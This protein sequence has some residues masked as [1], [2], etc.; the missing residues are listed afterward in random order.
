MFEVNVVGYDIIWSS[1]CTKKMRVWL[2]SQPLFLD[3]SLPDVLFLTI[4][5]YL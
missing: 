1:C 4:L 2:K 5:K 3:I